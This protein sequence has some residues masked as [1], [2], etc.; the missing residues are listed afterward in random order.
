MYEW[1]IIGPFEQLAQI[2]LKQQEWS[3]NAWSFGER[4]VLE[5][6]DVL[7]TKPV[8]RLTVKIPAQSFGMVTKM[9]N[10]LLSMS[11]EEGL[12]YPICLDGWTDIRSEWKLREPQNL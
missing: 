6:L 7:G 9:R 8:W 5:N 4:Q 3:E 10:I 11:F 1:L 2:I 12:T